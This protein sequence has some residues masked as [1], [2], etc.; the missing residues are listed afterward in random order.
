MEEYQVAYGEPGL[1]GFL[2]LLVV[3]GVFLYLKWGEKKTKAKVEKLGDDLKE[4][5]DKVK[6]RLK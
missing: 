6:D 3:V 1:I 2:L 5:A 4:I